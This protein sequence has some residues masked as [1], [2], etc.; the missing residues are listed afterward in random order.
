MLIS[1]ATTTSP[2]QE[3]SSGRSRVSDGELVSSMRS[4][5]AAASATMQS[6]F[7]SRRE[8]QDLQISSLHRLSSPP[9]EVEE[10]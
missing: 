4:A 5:T 7:G 6:G 1:T 9:V 2:A 8:G 3:S 10:V